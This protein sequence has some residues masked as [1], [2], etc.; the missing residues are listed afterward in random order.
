LRVA[1]GEKLRPVIEHVRVGPPGRQ[2]APDSAPFVEHDDP[3]AAVA[4][5]LGRE[6]AAHA[7]TNHDDIRM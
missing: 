7:G 3:Q 4:E 6:Q 1:R 5:R 2:A